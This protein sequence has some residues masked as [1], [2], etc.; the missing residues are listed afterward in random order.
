[1]RYGAPYWIVH[2]ADLQAAL[3]AR[4]RE[5]PDIDLR[6]G[7][8][9]EDIAVHAKGVTVVNRDGAGAHQ[10]AGAG[11]G[12]RRWRLVERSPPAFRRRAGDLL[13]SRGLAR[14]HRCAAAAARVRP[15]PRHALARRRRTPGRLSGARRRADQCRRDRR[16]RME[17]AGLERGRRRRRDRRRLQH[18]PLVRRRAHDHRRSRQLAEVGAVHRRWRAAGQ[19]P[20]RAHR[21]CRPR[22]AAV[23]GPGRGDGDRGRRSAG[24]LPVPP[25]RQRRP[26]RS[27]NT[28]RCGRRASRKSG[29]PPGSRARSIT[30]PGRSRSRATCR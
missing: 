14:H 2:R 16:R 15:E 8:P 10:P 29:A 17:Q 12:R 5:N 19:R 27:A 1:M 25:A 24:R 30:C 28:R 11:A 3:L 21:R 4:A 23:R 6:L 18:A 7:A 26:R 13:R 20:G 9:F 22:D